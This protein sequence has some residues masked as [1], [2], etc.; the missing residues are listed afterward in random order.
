MRWLRPSGRILRRPDRGES[1]RR[2]ADV[3]NLESSDTCAGSL[4]RIRRQVDRRPHSTFGV[5]LKSALCTDNGIWSRVAGKL[6]HRA[7]RAIRWLPVH[8]GPALPAR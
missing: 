2:W 4:T 1:A 3:V 8:P 6:L 5:D 7:A